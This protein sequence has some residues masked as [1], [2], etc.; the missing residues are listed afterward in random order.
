MPTKAVFR[1]TP[2]AAASMAQDIC[3]HSG[4]LDLATVSVYVND[5]FTW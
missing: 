5:T 4:V 1:Y 3:L 2:T